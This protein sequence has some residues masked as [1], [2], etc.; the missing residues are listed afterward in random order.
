MSLG[1]SI[2]D[3]VLCSQITYRLIT[4]ATSG[5]EKALRDLRELE[6]VLFGLSC[7]LGRLQTASSVILFRDSDT[8]D[9]A[10]FQQLGL[11]IHSCRQTLE[12]LEKATRKY[13]EI[14]TSDD[15][16][17]TAISLQQRRAQVKVQWRRIIWNI[18]DESLS[19]HR[20]KLASH[21]DAIN[22]LLNIFIWYVRYIQFFLLFL[23]IRPVVV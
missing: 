23:S 18:R 5:P 3:I 7:S 1:F 8:L 17:I 13:R 4:V 11:M 10:E 22:L 15:H 14:A 2:G 6:D 21:T 19:Q 9:A 20:R 12:E 16:P